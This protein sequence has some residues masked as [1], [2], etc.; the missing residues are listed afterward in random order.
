GQTK[1]DRTIQRCRYSERRRRKL[2]ASRSLRRRRRSSGTW[3][4]WRREL[5]LARDWTQCAGQRAELGGG[6][7]GEVV[8]LQE[9]L[10]IESAGN[11]TRFA[12]P[13]EFF[14]IIRGCCCWKK[15]G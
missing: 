7:R 14:V 6:R 5:R 2:W 10:A 13:H 11:K 3:R 9:T 8:L 12:H 15:R 4:W 1:S